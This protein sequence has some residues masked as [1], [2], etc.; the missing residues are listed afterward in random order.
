MI[1]HIAKYLSKVDNTS[2][3]KYLLINTCIACYVAVG[4]ALGIVVLHYKYGTNVADLSSIPLYPFILAIFVIFTS[5]AALFRERLRS[6]ILLI[7]G[8]ILI[9]LAIRWFSSSLNI[10]ISGVPDGNFSWSLGILTILVAYSVLVFTR[11]TLP[12]SIRSFPIVFYSP[13]GAILIS[14]VVEVGIFLEL[15]VG[16]GTRLGL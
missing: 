14:L 6:V 8:L 4:Q 13:I 16:I 1:K 12:T 7:H 9:G 5:I 3:K 2:P 10:L 11:F 15:A